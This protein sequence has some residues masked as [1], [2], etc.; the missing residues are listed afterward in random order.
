VLCLAAA[1]PASAADNGVLVLANGDRVTGDVRRLEHGQL[2]VK[3]GPMSTVYIK[4]THVTQLTTTATFE[5]E[6]AAGDRYVGTLVTA[7]AGRIAV[8]AAIGRVELDL[9]T[10]VR[11]RSIHERFWRRLDGALNVGASYTKSS[12][13]GQATID[14]DVHYRRP[15]FELLSSLSSSLSISSDDSLTTRSSLQFGY[16]RLLKRRWVVPA[17][18]QFEHNE[19]LGLEL[20]STYGGSVGRFLLQ[21]NRAEAI[22]AG[23]LVATHEDPVEG[24]TTD[25][26]EAILFVEHSFFTYDTPKT[27]LDFRFVTYPSL[28]DVGRVRLDLHALVTREIVRDFTIGVSMYDTFDSRP[29]TAGASKNDIGGSLTVGWTF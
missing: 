6:T 26:L 22:L 7:P 8:A 20:R 23:G 1:R 2:E 28:S 19:D 4:W 21:S 24:E 12:G 27:N 11:L 5:V 9:L 13:I 29:P 25:N 18:V 16:T 3:T 17:L 15:A 10:V 14:G